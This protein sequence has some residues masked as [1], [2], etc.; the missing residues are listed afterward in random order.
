M[1]IPKFSVE[2]PVLV[3]MLMVAILVAGVYTALT[4]T[5]E[6]FPESRPNQVLISTVYPGATPEEVEKGI[7][8]R[9]EEEI[10]DIEFIDKL[11]TRISEGL[12]VILV[13]LTNDV[14]DVAQKVNEFKS[15][16]DAIPR[17]EFPEEAEETRVVEFE[18][19]L[20][21]ISV[22]IYG[23]VDEATLKAAGRRLRDDLLLLPDI[24][25][26]ALDGIRKD[27][28]TVEVEP[29]KLIEYHLSLAAITDAIRRTNLDLPGGQLKTV[30]QN[31]ALR[32]LGETDEV[33]RIADTILI[34]GTTAG[35]QAATISRP[36]MGLSAGDSTAG[37]IVRVRDVGRVIDGFEDSDM[38]GRFN[39]QRGVNLTIYK[40]GDQDA[41]EIATRVKTFVA[42]K[43][44]EPP[45]SDWVTKLGLKPEVQRIY[46]QSRNDPYPAGLTLALHS[47]LS[48]YIIDRLKLLQRNGAWG[49]SL[50]FLSL[51]LT[52][53]WRVAFWV[54]MG[55]V[56][57]ICGGVLLMTLLGATLNLISMFGLIVV[58]GLIVDDAIVVGENIYARVERGEPPRLAAVRGAEE[59][60]WPVLVAVA[61]TIGAF[62]PLLF[63]EG[64]IGDFM[65]VLPIVVMSALLISLIE[66][67]MILPSH[68]ADTLKPVRRDLS[69]A[70]PRNRLARLIRPIRQKQHQ[71]FG[72]VVA[73]QYE[74]FLRKATRYRYVTLAS[75]VA[76]LLISLG[77][78]RGGHVEF[79]FMTKMDSETVLVNLEMPVGTPADQTENT[80]R[81]IENAILDRE[82]FPEVNSSYA[83]VGTQLQADEGGTIATSR[84]HL[85]QIIIEL[86]PVDQRTR[87]SDEITAAMR[88]NT[89]NI[90]GVNSLK[91]Q[92][93]QGGPAGAEIEIEVT[94]ERIA[95][96][97]SAIN[98]LK[99]KLATKPGV[100]DIDDDYEAGRRELQLTLLESAR[101]LGLTTQSLATEVRG[102]FYGLEARTL[103][104]DR[105]DVDIRVR[106]PED[107]RN[108]IYEL[109]AMRIATPRGGMVPLSEVARIDDAEGTASIRRIDQRR[110]LVV[111]ADV[112]QSQN[113]AERIIAEMAPAVSDLERNH[114]GLRIAFAGNKRETN[115][116]LVS[117]RRDFMIAI[118]IIFVMLA[119]LFKS[120]VHPL[121]VL[122]AVPF[123]VT[124]AIVGHY[125]MGYSMTILSMIGLVALTGI[126]V[127]DALILV[128]FIKKELAAGLPTIEAVISAGRRRL[129]PIILT[130]LTTI[131][132]LAPLMLEQSFQARF[133]IPMAISISFGLIFATVLTL[134]VVP[135]LYLIVEDLRA[136]AHW[137]WFGTA[138][139]PTPTSASEA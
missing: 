87:N 18:P 97:L 56:L 84:S 115:K 139:V 10:K 111:R 93:M 92:T 25:D 21:V 69:S 78:V 19:R 91:Y 49:L 127:N 17:D 14:T 29:E 74:R 88:Q 64:R 24:T 95:D 46:Q 39:G 27:E 22:A 36:G 45:P 126:V 16:I 44:G 43:R 103:Q 62:F 31:V 80:L 89:S 7:A 40:T 53:N 35:A 70:P 8:I 54:M 135:A 28:L 108:N 113:N 77:L 51:L 5:R 133:L 1:S 41:I 32:T 114:S 30:E 4:L 117:L 48:R 47:D 26:V 128:D 130:S 82:R 71:F 107:R 76:A 61:T 72:A 68:M 120:Y 85:G 100:H 66:A 112:D 101:P 94:S 11:E 118:L 52:L 2:N 60:T 6:M 124:G 42:A 83:L 86:S 123:G 59:V 34:S 38:R 136:A 98:V 73:V 65:G 131:L 90:A 75:A 116:S 109:E 99:E 79:V 104:R 106:F 129:R 119:G 81:V 57:S 9:I 122:A 13:S 37:R 137:L 63:I 50:V 15:A 3:N 134:V 20:P 125:L 110:A 132:G 33:E 105:E 67:L 121:V 102:A 12:S 138:Q 23:D 55:L 96:I 58:L